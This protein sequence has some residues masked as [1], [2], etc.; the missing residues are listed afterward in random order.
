M[1]QVVRLARHRRKMRLSAS[2]PP[3]GAQLM[4][5]P[6]YSEAS[7]CRGSPRLPLQPEGLTGASVITSKM[8][9]D[10][11]RVARARSP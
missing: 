5:L 3:K 7:S 6:I 10:A 11:V 9:D 1:R 2:M 8:Q 4:R